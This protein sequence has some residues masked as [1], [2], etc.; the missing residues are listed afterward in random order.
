MMAL[1]GL[2]IFACDKDEE[3]IRYAREHY[4]HENIEFQHLDLEHLPFEKSKWVGTQRMITAFEVIEHTPEAPYVLGQLLRTHTLLVGSVPNED[5]VP[6]ATTKG[7]PEHYRH[8]RPK[9]IQE[10]LTKLEWSVNFLGS[11]RGK[12]G[13]EALVRNVTNGRTLVFVAKKASL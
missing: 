8:Y 1:R 3:T 5:V 10:E 4:S 12:R 2:K 13:T 7:N 11:Q 6:F 9:E